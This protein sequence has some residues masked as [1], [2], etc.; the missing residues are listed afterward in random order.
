MSNRR[1]RYKEMERK[2]IFYLL[3]EVILFIFFLIA[4]GNGVTWLKVILAILCILGALLCLAF[5]Y[6]TRELTRRRSLWMSVTAG[7]VLLCT[8]VSLV[9]RFPSPNIYKIEK[10]ETSITQT[11]PQ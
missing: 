4:A 7:A 8:L 3:G 11:E 5:L 6:M 10:E 9:V 2:M 1:N